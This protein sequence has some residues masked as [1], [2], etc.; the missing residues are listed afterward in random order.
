[1]SPSEL[2]IFI[3][4]L[5][6][7]EHK[8]N[9]EVFDTFRELDKTTVLKYFNQKF[10]I[11]RDVV[12]LREIIKNEN[13]DRHD[14][15]EMRVIPTKYSEHISFNVTKADFESELVETLKRLRYFKTDQEATQ[16][17]KFYTLKA[18]IGS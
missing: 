9:R 17:S 5:S 11:E 8:V 3:D 2:N 15:N 13:E 4:V 10:E 1:M 12:K 6:G 7:L 14:N 16:N 18:L